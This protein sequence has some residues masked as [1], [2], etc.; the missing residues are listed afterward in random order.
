MS[1]VQESSNIVMTSHL[2][3]GVGRDGN[4][5]SS[6]RNSTGYGVPALPRPRKTEYLLYNFDLTVSVEFKKREIAQTNER[7]RVNFSIWGRLISDF[8]LSAVY[9]AGC[10]CRT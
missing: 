3:P 5:R 1:D 6:T 2:L 9:A 4:L 7:N 8:D 10:Y